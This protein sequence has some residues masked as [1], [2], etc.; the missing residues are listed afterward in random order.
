MNR[1][2]ICL[3]LLTA[4]CAAKPVEPPVEHDAP[5]ADTRVVDLLQS[6][7][8]KLDRQQPAPVVDLSPLEGELK[9][10]RSDLKAQARFSAPTESE[11]RSVGKVRKAE[12]FTGL[13]IYVS[14]NCSA[15]PAAERDY[16]KVLA[17]SKWER[18]KNIDLIRLGV[19]GARM[20][21]YFEIWEDGRAVQVIEGYSPFAVPVQVEKDGPYFEGPIWQYLARVP[22][23]T[24]DS[25]QTF[26]ATA[27]AYSSTYGG[28]STG[29]YGAASTGGYG[30]V[31]A[32]GGSN[33]GYGAGVTTSVTYEAIIPRQ[34]V[35]S[36]PV[37]RYGPLGVPRVRYEAGLV[38]EF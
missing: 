30:G 6:I 2:I 5:V 18:G 10:M 13:K 24:R 21:P 19:P 33:G 11:L 38:S 9:G 17:S 29:S 23:A 34:R 1:Y 12:G 20:V 26:S 27:G 7:S 35:V 32:A 8:G 14:T 31:Y 37:V 16:G 36:V 15:C 4:G 28:G 3:L 25:S 22:G